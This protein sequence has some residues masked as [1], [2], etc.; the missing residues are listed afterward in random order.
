VFRP[1]PIAASL[2]AIE[3]SGLNAGLDVF[4]ASRNSA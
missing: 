2:A 4:T 3:P 1:E